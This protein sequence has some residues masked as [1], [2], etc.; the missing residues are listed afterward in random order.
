MI[1]AGAVAVLAVGGG[2]TLAAGDQRQAVTADAARPAPSPTAPRGPLDPAAQ[3]YFDAVADEDVDALVDAFSPDAV[4]VDVGR[5]IRG[6]AE[7]RRW[8]RNEVVGGVYTVLDQTPRQG[9]TTILVRF[10]PG[11]AGGFRATYSFDIT[12]GLI[13]RADLQYA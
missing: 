13:V 6:H 3:R 8:A 4:V 2:V 9:G 10:Q 1:A 12:G 7:I 11:G 5:E